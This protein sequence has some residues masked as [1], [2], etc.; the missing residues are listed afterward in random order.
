MPDSINT[1]DIE[2][3]SNDRALPDALLGVIA[4]GLKEMPVDLIIVVK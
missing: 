2:A 1:A 4:I 3:V